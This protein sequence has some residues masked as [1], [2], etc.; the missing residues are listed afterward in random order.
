MSKYL[1]ISET[2]KSQPKTWLITGVAGFIGSNLLETLLKLNQKVIGLD[3]FSTG[4]HQNLKSVED[5]VGP[6][7]WKNFVLQIGDIKDIQTCVMA[8]SGVDKI[9]HQAAMCSVQQS[10]QDPIE[11]YQC[12]VMGFLNML[13]VARDLQI[14]SFVYASSSA[15]YG[16]LEALPALESN[17]CHPISPYALSKY[18]NELNAENFQRCYGFNSI[19]LRYFN[20]YG[21]RQAMS[22]G[23]VSV[24]PKWINAILNNE[25]ITI[26]GDGLSTRDYCHI[27]D[28]VQAN[29]LAATS[30][31]TEAQ[32][33]IY[34]IGSDK[35]TTLNVLYQGM[36]YLAHTNDVI[37]KPE[38]V[39]EPQPMGEVM[40]TQACND[41]AHFLLDF[42]PAVNLLEGTTRC[43][44]WYQEKLNG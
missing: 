41:K 9:L 42:I 14:K 10:I 30:E 36:L 37:Y 27:D 19:G 13:T 29:I 44:K 12:N 23:Y 24:I 16:D 40:H 8:C 20:V 2:L 7:L 4:T 28:V 1:K 11:T 33:Q 38:P 22:G 35:S 15:V 39:Y 31:K 21:Q 18:S 3:N 26:H 5:S 6:D 34:N 17:P 25:P 43:F 32:N